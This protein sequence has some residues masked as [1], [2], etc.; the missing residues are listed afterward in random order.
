MLR[1][2][3][4]LGSGGQ[5]VQMERITVV[6]EAH[7][8]LIHG[9]KVVVELCHIFFLARYDARG[10]ITAFWQGLP[11]FVFLEKS[12]GILNFGL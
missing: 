3:Y 11:K 8:S 6:K 12:T 4:R 10:A 7:M 5:A 9:I 2:F 1:Q